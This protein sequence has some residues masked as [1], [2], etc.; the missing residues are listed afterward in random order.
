MSRVLRDTGG[1]F[2]IQAGMTLAQALLAK[3]RETKTDS[4]ARM[5]RCFTGLKYCD[6]RTSFG[7]SILVKNVNLNGGGP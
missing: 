7:L 3:S 4:E 1:S 5:M 2:I 6:S